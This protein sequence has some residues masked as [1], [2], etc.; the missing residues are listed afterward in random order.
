MNRIVKLLREIG[1]SPSTYPLSTFWL[2][3]IIA[4]F[5]LGTGW[6]SLGTGMVILTGALIFLVVVAFRKDIQQ[7]HVLVN[8][9]HD[10]LLERVTQLTDL[11]KESGVPVPYPRTKEGSGGG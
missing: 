4:V 3:A 1:E 7:V 6:W 10:D 8:S 2:V 5:G 11:L 9:Q